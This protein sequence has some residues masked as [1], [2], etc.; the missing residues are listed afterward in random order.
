MKMEWD[1]NKINIKYHT[2]NDGAQ[3]VHSEQIL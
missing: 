1:Y 3:L 2:S